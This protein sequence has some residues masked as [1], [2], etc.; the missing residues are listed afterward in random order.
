MCHQAVLVMCYWRGGVGGHQ[1][2][3]GA[4]VGKWGEPFLLVDGEAK[5]LR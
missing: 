1:Q 2:E 3:G 5:V 4:K